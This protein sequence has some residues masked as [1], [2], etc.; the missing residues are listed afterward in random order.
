MEK[1]LDPDI[2]SDNCLETSGCQINCRYNYNNHGYELINDTEVQSLYYNPLTPSS[3]AYQKTIDCT[4][5]D[6]T[7]GGSFKHSFTDELI[8][9]I[10]NSTLPNDFPI[11]YNKNSRIGK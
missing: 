7:S 3:G 10:Y 1:R 8:F 5:T 9:D 2:P 4:A 6:F 11:D